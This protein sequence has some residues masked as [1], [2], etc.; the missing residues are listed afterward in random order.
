MLLFTDLILILLNRMNNSLSK[1]MP[2]ENLV[3]SSAFI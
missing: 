3:Q 2:V 1:N